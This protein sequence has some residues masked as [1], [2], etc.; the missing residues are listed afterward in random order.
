MA[1]VSETVQLHQRAGEWWGCCPFH[2]EKSPSFKVNPATGLWKCFGCGKGGDVFSFVMERENLEFGDALRFLA[3]RSG[4]E[5]T[6]W[7]G[8]REN[9]PKRSKLTE[10]LIEAEAFYTTMLLSGRDS[11]A[12]AAREYL[13]RRGF[14]SDVSR[15]WG[16]GFAPGRQSLVRH[17]KEKGFSYEEMEVADLAINRSGSYQ[18]RFYNRVMFPIH[19]EHGST[20][21]FGGRVLGDAKPKYL[22]SRDTKVFHKGQRLFAYDKAKEHITASR[23]AIICEGYT[24]VIA[25]HEAGMKNVCAVL[26]TAL[27]ADHLKLLDRC[28]T[29]QVI[30]VFDGD[31]AGQRAAERAIRFLDSSTAD[32]RCVILPDGLDPA[33]YLEKHT[34]EELRAELDRSRSLLD[35][36]FAKRLESVDLS[37]PGRRVAALDD[38]AQLLAPL[39]KSVLFDSYATRLADT[40]GAD[41]EETKRLIRSKPIPK[42]DEY[43]DRNKAA[44]SDLSSSEIR[45]GGSDD[46]VGPVDVPRRPGLETLSAAERAQ[47]TVERELLTLMCENVELIRP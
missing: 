7:G 22:N 37:I 33:D 36:V 30:L 1:L 14:G 47:L 10:C 26:G 45:R 40:L 16:L 19:D 11:R 2:Q 43:T 24:D 6:S 41:L 25:M 23:V 21:A 28:R 31:E 15:R 18:D 44:E 29:E 12:Q 32:L 34:V 5:L 35:F 17:L 8:E 3:E 38:L 20:I 13:K 42:F 4:I 39:K 9:G 27:T 46:S